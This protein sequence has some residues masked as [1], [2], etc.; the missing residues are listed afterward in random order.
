M[1]RDPGSR[2][3]APQPSPTPRTP[4]RLVEGAFHFSEQRL[5]PGPCSPSLC[6]LWDPEGP[7]GTAQTGTGGESVGSNTLALELYLKVQTGGILP[8]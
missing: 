4:L 5:P 6:P 2:D 7:P 1:G 3:H 8:I